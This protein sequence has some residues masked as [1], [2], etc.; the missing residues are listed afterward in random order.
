MTDLILIIF[1]IGAFFIQN[2]YGKKISI[3]E[4]NKDTDS[5][6]MKIKHDNMKPYMEIRHKFNNEYDRA[7]PVTTEEKT[8]EYLA[9]LL[10]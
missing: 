8:K 1:A 3:L 5:D 7:N 10:G 6:Q 9:F 4:T 2:F